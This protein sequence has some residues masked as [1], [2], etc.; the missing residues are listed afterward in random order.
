MVTSTTKAMPRNLPHHFVITIDG[1]SISFVAIVSAIMLPVLGLTT[2][3]TLTCTILNLIADG[4]DTNTAGGDIH[5]R[6]L[7]N[8]LA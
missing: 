1:S 8:T 4:T 6:E 5:C 2:T 7:Q 3:L